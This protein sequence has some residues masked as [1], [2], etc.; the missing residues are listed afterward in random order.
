MAISSGSR[1][2]EAAVV[3]GGAPS[4]ADLAALREF[5]GDA[6]VVHVA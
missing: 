3:M 1:G 4:E 5:A 6:V 2:L